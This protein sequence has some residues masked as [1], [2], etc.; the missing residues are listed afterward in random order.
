MQDLLGAA[1]QLDDA[2]RDRHQ[3]IDGPQESV[4]VVRRAGSKL[5]HAGLEGAATRHQCLEIFGAVHSSAA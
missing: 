3:L 2:I 5:E 1:D 4:M